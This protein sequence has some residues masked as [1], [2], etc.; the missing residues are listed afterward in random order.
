[1]ELE[2]IQSREMIERFKKD[3]KVIEEK[4][5]NSDNNLKSKAKE[6][7]DQFEIK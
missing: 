5:H 3:I 4:L 1:M 6:L 2:A 7:S